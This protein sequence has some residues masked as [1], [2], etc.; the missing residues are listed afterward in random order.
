MDNEIT[1]IGQ[2]AITVESVES[3]LA[4]YRDILGLEFLFAPSD[5][6]ASTSR[7]VI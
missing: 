5:T 3:S 4:F 2:L 7:R 1:E 6:L